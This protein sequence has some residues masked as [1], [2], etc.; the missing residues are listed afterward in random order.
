M[1][2]HGFRKSNFLFFAVV[3]SHYNFQ[4]M[5]RKLEFDQGTSTENS[6]TRRNMTAYS[7]RLISCVI[8]ILTGRY[9]FL[10]FF[11]FF[12]RNLLEMR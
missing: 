3:Q 7:E 12:P 9:F 1:R 8:Y 2:K 5:I 11:F 4:I 10:A 6:V